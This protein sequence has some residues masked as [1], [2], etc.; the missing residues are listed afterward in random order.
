MGAFKTLRKSDIQVLPYPANKS[1]VATPTT[2]NSLGIRIFVGK[3]LSSSGYFKSGSDPKTI[4]SAS[5]ESRHRRLIYESVKQLYYSNYLSSSYISQ[6]GSFDNFDQTTIYNYYSTSYEGSYN[7]VQKYFPTASN[8]II[9]VLSI[10]KNIFGSKLVPGTIQISGSDF[11]IFDDKE[12]NLFNVSSSSPS[13]VELISSTITG[14]SDLTPAQK[15]SFSKFYSMGTNLTVSASFV[16]TT[17]SGALASSSLIT[18]NSYLFSGS[19]FGTYVASIVSIVSQSVTWNFSLSGSDIVRDFDGIGFQF[20]PQASVIDKPYIISITSSVTLNGLNIVNYT[21]ELVGNVVYPHGII[22]ITNPNYLTIF[23][24]ASTDSF[25]GGTKSGSF[26]FFFKGENVV[27]ENEVRCQVSEDEFNY[28]LNPSVS[29]D[30]SGSLRDFTT[31]SVFN[32]YVTTMGLYNE[33]GE[34]LV[35]GKLGQPVFIPRNSDINFILRY[36]S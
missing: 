26:N 31:S 16:I 20:F 6:T 36:D 28:T 12:G 9:R 27:Y 22:A 7:G 3:N 15:I 1:W 33:S 30:H 32:P 21:R 18:F 2:Y 11:N 34:L 10:P 8:S 4:D 35:V 29:S 25:S 17:I 24:T 23:P 14:S 19:D 5:G 13:N